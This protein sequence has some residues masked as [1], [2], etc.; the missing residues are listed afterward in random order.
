MIRSV[1]LCIL[2]AVDGAFCML[3]AAEGT[4]CYTGGA[5]GDSLCATLM[6]EAVEGG[7]C[8]PKV[9][10]VLDVLEG[11]EV[12]EAMLLCML[13][14]LKVPEVMRCV[15]LC[16]PKAVEDEPLS[17]LEFSI[18]AI[19]SMAECLRLGHSPQHRCLKECK[20]G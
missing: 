16:I 2:P 6:L 18:V 15:V 19:F 10:K 9:L 11:L 20:P 12:P 5:G 14:G 3:E 17:G 4:F 7:L 8:L 1:L 13:E